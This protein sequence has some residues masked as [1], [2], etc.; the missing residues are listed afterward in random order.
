VDNSYKWASG[1][2]LSSAE[3]LVKFGSALLAPGFLQAE[4]LDLLFTSQQTA[5]GA[6]TGYGIGWF[7]ATDG[8]GHRWLFHGGSAIGGTAVFGLDRDSRLVIAI[9]S[10]VSDAPLEPGRAIQPLFDR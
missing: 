9:L 2:F 1:G 5:A 10:N 6:A 7:V 3:D 4:T 8:L